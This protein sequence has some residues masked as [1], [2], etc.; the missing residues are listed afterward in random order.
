MNTITLTDSVLVN[1]A[2]SAT[3][4]SK[5]PLLNAIARATAKKGGCGSCGRR[6]KLSGAVLAVRTAIVGSP[7]AI[8]TVKELLSANRLIAYIRGPGGK[9]VRKEF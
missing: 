9:T 1:L 3:A 2:N 8:R 7:A 6:Q 5:L 4:R